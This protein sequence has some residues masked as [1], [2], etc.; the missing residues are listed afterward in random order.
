MPRSKKNHKDQTHSGRS[1]TEKASQKPDKNDKV[2]SLSKIVDE[3][4]EPLITEKKPYRKEDELPFPD[5]GSQ[6]EVNRDKQK[7]TVR[8]TPDLIARIQTA[9]ETSGQDRN[10][11]ITEQLE[12]ALDITAQPLPDQTDT[13]DHD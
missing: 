4:M 5:L 3:V 11:W 13:I 10:T 8:F 12:K 1:A 9:A 2:S 7:I 6:A